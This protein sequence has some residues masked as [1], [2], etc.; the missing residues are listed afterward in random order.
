MLRG[1]EITAEATQQTPTTAD[2]IGDRSH[3]TERMNVAFTPAQAA[4]VERTAAR[5]GWSKSVLTREAVFRFTAAVEASRALADP[6]GPL[7][8][9][10][11]AEEAARR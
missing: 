2:V 1:M 5:L 9:I 10:V 8:S 4:L 7:L 6:T 11:P 3:R